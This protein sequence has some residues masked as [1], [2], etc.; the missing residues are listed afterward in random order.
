MPDDEKPR[1]KEPEAE[2]AGI[3]IAPT[4]PFGANRAMP[5]AKFITRPRDKDDPDIRF[6]KDDSWRSG[7]EEED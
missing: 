2:W 1:D 5:S 3:G 4:G 7:K 6:R